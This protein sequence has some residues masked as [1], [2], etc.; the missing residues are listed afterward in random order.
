MSDIVGVCAVLS[1]QPIPGVLDVAAGAYA[2]S[3]EIRH[4]SVEQLNS[5]Q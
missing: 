2:V 5:E 4:C 3:L 1:M